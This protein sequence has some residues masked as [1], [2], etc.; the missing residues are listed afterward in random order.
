MKLNG[1]NILKC[2]KNFQA[3]FFYPSIIT[4]R[5]NNVDKEGNDKKYCLVSVGAWMDI[6]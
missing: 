6:G 3:L 1:I 5:V 2:L 4:L